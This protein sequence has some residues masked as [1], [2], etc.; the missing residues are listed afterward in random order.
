MLANIKKTFSPMPAIL[1]QAQEGKQAKWNIILNGLAAFGVGIGSVYT[2]AVAMIP[3]F[4]AVGMI[5]GATGKAVSPD[6]TLIAQLFVT[7]MPIVILTLYVKFAEKRSVRSMGFVKEHA[8][9]D[10]LLGMVIAFAMFSA[11]VGIC[12]AGGAMSFGG[13]V[14]GGRYL[15][16]ALMFLGFLVQGASEETV[17]RGFMMTSFG[18]KGGALAGMLFNSLVFGLLHLFNSGLNVLPMIN[19]ILFGVFMSVLVL[20]LNSIWMACAIHSV[21]NFVQGNF[22]GILVS[23]NDFG[24]SVFRFES[25]EGMELLNGGSFGMEGGIATS[26]VLTVSIIIALLLKP[27]EAK[28]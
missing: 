28:N 17:C 27:R 24:P 20:K 11:C 3:Y 26:V 18:S 5:Y 10:Y 25:T 7:F 6:T 9:T 14:L 16:L 1:A 23:G 13:Y 15:T 8:V 21:W 12:A 4:I 2:E 22:Y 19:L